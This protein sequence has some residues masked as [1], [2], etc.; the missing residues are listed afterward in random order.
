MTSNKRSFR[1][2]RNPI[3]CL[4]LLAAFAAAAGCSTAESPAGSGNNM[5]HILPSGS[6][7][8]GWL[9][10]PSGGT[11][12]SSATLDYIANNGSSG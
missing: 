8:S 9:V 6:S 7:V 11:H 2:F 5:N 12:T 1:E 10:T 3:G 4:I